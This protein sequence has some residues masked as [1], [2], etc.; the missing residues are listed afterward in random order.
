MDDMEKQ[1]T[2][3][4]AV[5]SIKPEIMRRMGNVDP[6]I[7]GFKAEWLAR[8]AIEEYGADDPVKMLNFIS[9]LADQAKAAFPRYGTLDA[10]YKLSRMMRAESDIR[11]AGSV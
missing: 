2:I 8:H 4:R 1:G 7:D 10:A 9:R 11:E 5:G 6:G 3:D